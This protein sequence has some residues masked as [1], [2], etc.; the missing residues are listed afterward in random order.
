MGMDCIRIE[1]LIS[2][3][4]DGE[5]APSEAG[6]VRSHLGMCSMCQQEYETLALLSNAFKQTPNALLIAPAGFKDAVMLKIMNDANIEVRSNRL[7]W[8]NKS[9]RKLATGVAA[10]LLII[11]GAAS[12]NFAPPAQLADNNPSVN[13]SPPTEIFNQLPTDNKDP[14]IVT[15]INKPTPP[16]QTE[17]NTPVGTEPHTN[18]TTEEPPVTI[19]STTKSAPV[20]LNHERVI[21]TTI[22]K[23]A[24]VDSAQAQEKALQI[25]GA[26][27]AQIQNLGQQIN[28]SGSY[29]AL[30]I[31]VANANAS[32]LITKLGDLGT[33]TGQEVDKQ[34]ISTHYTETL[35]QYQILVTQRATLPDPSQKAQL[36]QRIELLED[37]L[38]AWEQKAEQETIVLWLEK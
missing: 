32:L 24:V 22:L 34:D 16:A 28:E 26:S 25:A 4:L 10:A 6:E 7:H 38:Q 29:T 14:G 30:K 20:F 5:L 33:I 13:T 12:I 11:I 23:V 27:Q 31:T 1:Q 36:D 3:Y 2:P 15:P 9:W 18:P 8:F 21:K 35:S 37:E 17:P 19:A